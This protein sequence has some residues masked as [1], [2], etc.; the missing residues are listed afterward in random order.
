M[1]LNAPACIVSGFGCGHPAGACANADT[2]TIPMAN[3]AAASVALSRLILFSP[4][5]SRSNHRMNASQVPLGACGMCYVEEEQER[6]A[7]GNSGERACAAM[8]EKKMHDFDQQHRR[9]FFGR[10]AGLS[11]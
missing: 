2:A 10:I 4:P 5:G 8:R 7:S 9:G 6:R 1:S 11:S 3:A